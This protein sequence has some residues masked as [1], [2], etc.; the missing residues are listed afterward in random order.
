MKR[1]DEEHTPQ[2][3][4]EPPYEPPALRI[5][6]S[7]AELTRGGFSGSFDGFEEQSS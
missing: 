1:D 6:G 2:P 3:A 4:P 7:F 5:I